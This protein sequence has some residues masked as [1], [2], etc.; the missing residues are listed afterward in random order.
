MLS[1]TLLAACSLTTTP[2]VE[3]Q[4][5]LDCRSAFG[6]GSVCD[7][8]GL[9]SDWEPSPR[10]ERTIPQDLFDNK[11]EYRDLIV[12]GSVYERQ[13]SLLD[14]MSFELAITQV[15]DGAGLD[16][17]LYGFVQCSNEENGDWDDA[18]AEEANVAL[19][20]TLADEVGVP[21]ILGPS[22]SSRT[23]D[24]Y[25]A[26]GELDTLM[27]SPSATS[28]T[29]TDLDPPAT[30]ASPGLLWR[31]APPDSIQ[32]RAIALDLEA[33]GVQ[34][35]S[36]VYNDDQAYGTG[37]AQELTSVFGGSVELYPWLTPTDRDARTVEAGTDNSE[38]VMFVSSDKGDATAFLNAAAT[39]AGYVDKG[40]YLT[41]AAYDTNI[42]DN[43]QSASALFPNIRGTRPATP[44]GD[45]YTFFLASFSGT[46]GQ[47][48]EGSAFPAYAYDAAWIVIYGTAWAQLQ[49]GSITGT[50]IARGLRQLSQG[51]SV[52]IQGTSW[53]TV[54]SAFSQGNGIDV[55]GASGALDYDPV[56]EETAGPIDL[57]VVQPNGRD[58]E[59]VCTFDPV[60]A[61]ALPVAC[62]T[63]Q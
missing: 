46:Y 61:D 9:C 6:W 12:L 5:N 45:V 50:N 19:A 34:R 24:A 20:R 32:A 41:D 27:I 22:Y 2:V 8:D 44:V 36:I 28:P 21:A 25:T 38:V 40:I 42:L 56:T 57:W 11:D 37:L 3:C 53:S 52:R 18:T 62:G 58:F 51:P 35:V 30:D 29:L 1:L 39:V 63:L 4:S 60:A 17:Q 10:C 14:V 31:T 47:S 15:N 26:I 54:T 59:V 16:G 55:I 33:A 49:E 7:D 23:Q 48:A 43:A 13:E